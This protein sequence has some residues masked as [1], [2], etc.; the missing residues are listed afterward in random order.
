MMYIIQL[1]QGKMPTAA[2]RLLWLIWIRDSPIAF[3]TSAEDSLRHRTESVG[4]VQPHVK[5]KLVN[6]KGETVPVGTPGEVCIS[7][8]L[9]QKG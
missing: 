5:A 8:Y 7:G 6:P 9:T 4:R 3:Q 2:R 1:R